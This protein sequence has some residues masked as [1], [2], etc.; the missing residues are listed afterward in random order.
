MTSGPSAQTSS[1]HGRGMLPYRR[2]SSFC[3]WTHNMNPSILMYL[4]R[5]PSEES[6]LTSRIVRAERRTGQLRKAPVTS[7]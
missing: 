5:L 7:S 6:R 4:G 2:S 3:C 1:L